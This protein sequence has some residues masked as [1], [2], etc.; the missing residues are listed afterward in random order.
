MCGFKYKTPTVITDHVAVGDNVSK[1]F[2]R[3]YNID[4]IVIPNMLDPDVKPE[5]VL[6]L[7]SATRLTNEKGLDRIVALCSKLKA[8]NKKFL[9]FIYGD[10]NYAEAVNRLRTIPE[11]ILMPVSDDLTSYIADSTYFVH[12]SD[13]EGDPYCTK[14]AL[15][16]NVPCIV[17]NYPAAKEQ[18]TDGVNGYILNM[19]LSNL[20]ID[21]IYNKIPKFKYEEV[22]YEQKWLDF[23][24]KPIGRLRTPKTVINKTETN[25][26][27]PLQYNNKNGTLL[28]Y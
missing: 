7:I 14:E 6:R 23:L 21:K 15:Q 13:T 1:V 5:K 4:S 20:D 16:V 18:I 17:T 3:M 12:L 26:P 24:G 9:W 28:G 27:E 11:V 25:T 10:G 2:K 8:A 19:D 22:N